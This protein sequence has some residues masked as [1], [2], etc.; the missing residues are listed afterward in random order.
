VQVW[1][2]SRVLYELLPWA[3]AYLR[4]PQVQPCDVLWESKLHSRGSKLEDQREHMLEA[5]LEEWVDEGGEE[6]L[7]TIEVDCS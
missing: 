3:T 1:L 2:I 4:I 6:C 7:R 5:K